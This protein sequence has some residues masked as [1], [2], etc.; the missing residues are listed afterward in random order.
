MQKWPWA[1]GDRKVA[2][3]VSSFLPAIHVIIRKRKR[4]P[5]ILESEMIKRTHKIFA[6]ILLMIGVLHDNPWVSLTEP[7]PHIMWLSLSCMYWCSVMTG[8]YV[9][10]D[11]V[12]QN[13]ARKEH[14]FVADNMRQYYWVPI[15][16]FSFWTYS[17]YKITWSPGMY[18]NAIGF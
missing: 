11:T 18:G 7:F 8:W 13:Y 4:C 10:T 2:V 16:C 5:G 14:A 15:G 6:Y 9:Y 17:P 3:T 1:L 12:R